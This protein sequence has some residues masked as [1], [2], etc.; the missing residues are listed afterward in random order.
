MR[1]RSR[2]AV[3]AFAFLAALPAAAAD[4]WVGFTD[5]G[6]IFTVSTPKP[7]HASDASTTTKNGVKIAMTAYGVEY[8]G[9]DMFAVAGDYT[10]LG[11]DPAKALANGVKAAT[12]HGRTLLADTPLT[13]DGHAGREIKASD[14]GGN[15]YIDRIFFF[16]DHLYQ[17]IIGLSPGASAAQQAEGTRFLQSLH[18]LH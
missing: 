2:L 8:D 17:I 10:G 16:D 6:R 7:L 1:L 5:P 4:D 9:I 11:L 18:F 14:P 13:V 3:F 12:E 15:V